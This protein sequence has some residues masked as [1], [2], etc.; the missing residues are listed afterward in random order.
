MLTFNI[1]DFKRYD[2][3]AIHPSSVVAGK[4]DR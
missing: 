4:R 1:D 2:I 3:E